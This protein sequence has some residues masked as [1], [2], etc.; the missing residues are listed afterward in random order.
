MNF[1]RLPL[2][3]FMLL[4]IATRWIAADSIT[5]SHKR[6][7][8]TYYARLLARFL[9][10]SLTPEFFALL[11]NRMDPLYN[12]DGHLFHHKMCQHVHRTHLAFVE[13]IKTDIRFTTYQYDIPKYIKFLCTNLRLVSSNSSL[14]S[15]HKDLN[16][17]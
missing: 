3:S 2:I 13:S 9:Q 14:A 16:L 15:A 12:N 1:P 6:G 17:H 10:N 11:L 7:S 8:E 4:H 5:E